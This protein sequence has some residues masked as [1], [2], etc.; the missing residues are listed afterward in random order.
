MVL[1][2]GGWVLI[3][4]NRTVLSPLFKILALEWGLSKTQLGFLNSAFFLIYTL[5]Q[6]P[7]GLLA[8]RFQRKLVLLPG[9]LLQGLGVLAGGLAGGY[10]PFLL[11][12]LATGLGQSTFYATQYA[13]AQG[14]I[15]LEKRAL[16]TSVINSG[17][18]FGI[19]G[20][21]ALG[22]FFVYNLRLG[23]RVP[24]FLLSA[25][26]L[27][28]TWL[29]AHVIVEKNDPIHPGRPGANEDGPPPGQRSSP[30]VK[31]P[32]VSR[33]TLFSRDLTLSYL[34]VFSTMYG[35]FVILTWLPFYL[36]TVR[37][38]SGEEAGLVSILVPFCAVPAGLLAGRISD[39]LGRRRSVMLGLLPFSTL[40][41]L[42][43]VLATNRL[44]LILGLILYGA[45]GKLVL[46]PL[47]VSMVADV[48]P[49]GIYATAFGVLNFV[50]T[51]ST[52]L[53][54]AITGY[55]AD[56]TG[57]FN[58]GFYLAA[59]L[60]GLAFLALLGVREGAS[61]VRSGR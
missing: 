7:T 21:L 19:A 46:D 2:F 45:A 31:S 48:T 20:G 49:P 35:F 41:L 11:S 43:I 25:F 5:M 51:I 52:V 50:G 6:V 55:L 42:L 61:T 24:F 60:Q 10:F 33:I 23:W 34:T 8:D 47:M 16:G 40:A 17:M 4:A 13:L 59:S 28:L 26:T 3:Y 38:Y 54:P 1:F 15:P 39:L 44:W 30:A 29:M 14:A 32:G 9:F 12:R 58:S 56:L 53:A 18:A 22:S 57:S 36:Q 27:A 37:G